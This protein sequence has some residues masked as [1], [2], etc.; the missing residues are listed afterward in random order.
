MRRGSYITAIGKGDKYSA[1]THASVMSL[2]ALPEMLTN[3]NFCFMSQDIPDEK[4]SS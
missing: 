3:P 2:N 1:L 4:H